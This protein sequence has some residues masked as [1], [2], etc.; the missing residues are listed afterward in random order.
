MELSTLV[1][2]EKM[3]DTVGV[4]KCGLMVQNIKVCGRTILLMEKDDSS[5]MTALFMKEFG[6]TIK[7]TV[8][9]L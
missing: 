5:S 2:G 4:Y 8:K 3:S 7:L 9:G 1:S 6:Q